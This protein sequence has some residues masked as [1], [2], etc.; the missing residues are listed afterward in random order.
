MMTLVLTDSRTATCFQAGRRGFESRPPLRTEVDWP[1]GR[2]KAAGDRQL[3]DRDG[4]KFGKPSFKCDEERKAVLSHRL[5]VEPRGARDAEVRPQIRK[6]LVGFDSRG[7]HVDPRE[8][9]KRE[10]PIGRKHASEL[11]RGPAQVGLLDDRRLGKSPIY[12]T[13]QR[14]RE[15]HT[16]GRLHSQRHEEPFRHRMRSAPRPCDRRSGSYPTLRPDLHR[17]ASALDRLC[18]WPVRGPCAGS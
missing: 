7:R 9:R 15:G 17:L 6:A 2:L 10:Q 4:A 13:R 5:G 1:I 3:G 8:S 16:I 18:R 11:H 12:A 14:R